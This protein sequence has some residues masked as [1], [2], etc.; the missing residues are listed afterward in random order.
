MYSEREL[1]EKV[2][3]QSRAL[4]TRTGHLV[5]LRSLSNNCE[6][7]MNACAIKNRFL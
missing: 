7:P 6:D 3:I 5:T 4:G 1:G 2:N